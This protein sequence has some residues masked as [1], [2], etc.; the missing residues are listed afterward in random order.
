MGN[1][2]LAQ[3][4][5]LPAHDTA[6]ERQPDS[7]NGILSLVPGDLISKGLATLPPASMPG[8]DRHEV[9]IDAGPLG[10]VRLSVERKRVK[11][12]RHSHYYWSAWRADA[13]TRS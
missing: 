1:S 12:G 13:P 7:E 8:A 10:R 5:Q 4:C 9:E 6:G 2:K 3:G 11:H